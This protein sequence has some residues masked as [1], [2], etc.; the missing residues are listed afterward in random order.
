MRKSIEASL[1]KRVGGVTI[2]PPS[3]FSNQASSKIR[4][5][6]PSPILH[7]EPQAIKFLDFRILFQANDPDKEF[8]SKMEQFGKYFSLK[9]L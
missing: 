7:L 5:V 8:A 4:I 6:F 2:L 1:D 9:T 3:E